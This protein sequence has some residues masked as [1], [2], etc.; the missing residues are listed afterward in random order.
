MGLD[1]SLLVIFIFVYGKISSNMLV[2]VFTV[3]D[4][5][6]GMCQLFLYPAFIKLLSFF[7]VFF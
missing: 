6:K 3:G 1:V 5:L 4:F 2:A 7:V